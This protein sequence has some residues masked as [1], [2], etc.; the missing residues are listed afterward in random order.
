MEGV[1][2]TEGVEG[3]LGGELWLFLF[4]SLVVSV[5]MWLPLLTGDT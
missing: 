2:D 4:F 1:E 3:I 5:S